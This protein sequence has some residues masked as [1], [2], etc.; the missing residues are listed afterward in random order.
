MSDIIAQSDLFKRHLQRLRSSLTAHSPD[1]ICEFISTHTYLRS[2]P[3]SFDGHEY[4]EEILR[5]PAQNKVILK[6]AQ[7]GISEMSARMALARSVLTP[8]FSTIYTLPA[9]STAAVFMKT[10]IEPVINSSQYLSELVSSNLDNSMV[11]QFGDS[12]L[13]LKGCQVDRQAIS[14]PADMLIF[15]EVDNS[16]QDVM[17]LFES[18][19]IHS[20][21][22]LTIKL[23]TPTVPGFGISKAYALSKRKLQFAKCPHCG[24]WF[25]P[26]YHQHVRIPGYL[27]DLEEITKRHFANPSFRWKEAYIECPQCARPVDLRMALRNWVVENPDDAFYDSGYRVSP[28]DCPKTILVSDLVKSSTTYERP[29]DFHNQRLGIPK[30]DKES[31]LERDE[32]A[33]AIVTG[34]VD[35]GF[36][37]VLG[38]DLGTTCHLVVNSVLA[39][40]S[41]VTVYCEKIPL[42]RVVQR[43]IELFLRFKCRMMVVDRGPNTEA[44]YQI[45]QKIVNCFAGVFTNSKGVEFFKVV[46][47]E[48][49]LSEGVQ[50]IRQ[51]NISKD[52]AMDI[53]MF[54]VRNGMILKVSD[55]ENEDWIEQLMD[56]K[57]IRVFKNDEQVFTWVKTEG[58]DHYHM[59]ELYAL[60]ASRILGVATG[61]TSGLRLF[62]KIKVEDTQ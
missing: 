39:D 52:T 4:Q 21:Y 47:K 17:T 31:S 57:R 14:T 38:L 60:I 62:S 13:W 19:L 44:V 50:G 24:H 1:S 36:S 20:E 41:M 27:D 42:H 34:S 29:Q 55:D 5:D 22:K 45:Q 51:V 3:F 53:L 10:R 7:I 33:A 25:Y 11:K 26:E 18:R 32:L 35:M 9:A 46:E 37:N 48:N 59:A 28:F 40:Q 2:K 8:G 49:D 30:A 23:S 15:D 43:T 6:S 58:N 56:N 16:D 61:V 54:M 12:Y